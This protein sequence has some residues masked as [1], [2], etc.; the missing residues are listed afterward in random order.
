MA[1]YLDENEDGAV[2]QEEFVDKKAMPLVRSIFGALD[3]DS[4]GIVDLSEAWME[5]I[6]SP[7]FIRYLSAELFKFGDLTR[8]NFLSNEDIPR[9]IR[10]G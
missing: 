1:N 9:A 4:N 2:S 10:P 8:D 7:P 3:V 5:N 6:L